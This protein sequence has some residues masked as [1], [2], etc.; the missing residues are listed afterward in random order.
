MSLAGSSMLTAG[1]R[2]R[3]YQQWIDEGLSCFAKLHNNEAGSRSGCFFP[4][5]RNR[6]SNYS[7]ARWQEIVLPIAWSF[8]RHHDDS[9]LRMISEGISFWT[10][11]QNRSGSFPQYCRR[12]NDFAATAF[13]SYA[14]AAALNCIGVNGL[15][16][17][18]LQNA[19]VQ[20]CLARTGNWL[21]KNNENVYSNQQMAAAL[22]LLEISL[23]LEDSK[24]ERSAG[25]KLTQ[26][27]RQQ[28]EG[29]FLE[30]KG[31]D[32]GYST[33]TLELLSRFLLRATDKDQ[34][35]DIVAAVELYFE[36]LTLRSTA[37]YFGSG[38]RSTDWAITGGFELFAPSIRK[39]KK[40][41]EEIFL[42]QDVRHLH[43]TRHIHTDL[44]RLCFAYDQ[45]VVDF[46]GSLDGNRKVKY[47]IVE[48]EY[49]VTLRMLRPFGLHKF[50]W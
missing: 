38:V 13:S 21:S 49:K 29:V 28:K 41:L 39:A 45:A 20:D 22:A 43:D 6:L 12:D 48:S 7:N 36:S 31:F 18:S 44:C 17:S 5:Y 4:P 1:L 46:P 3:I 50:R 34:K 37:R 14:V 8:V 19:N 16:K 25:R 23:C 26:V 47:P 9:Q 10:T 15:S 24:F 32:I 40:L 42:K 33:L 11:L 35:D 2:R 27:L 30:K